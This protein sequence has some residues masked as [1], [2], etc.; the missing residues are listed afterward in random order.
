MEHYALWDMFPCPYQIGTP[1]KNTVQSPQS[2]VTVGSVSECKEE[3][4]EHHRVW[5]FCTLP[6]TLFLFLSI[7]W[8]NETKVVCIFSFASFK[9]RQIN[10]Y[11]EDIL[12]LSMQCMYVLR[13]IVWSPIVIPVHLWG[14]QSLRRFMWSNHGL[15]SLSS[16]ASPKSSFYL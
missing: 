16:W 6:R 11:A 1:Y 5:S 2:A 12:V 7:F 14:N 4:K 13:S 3:D 9:V 10:L 15:P 8:M